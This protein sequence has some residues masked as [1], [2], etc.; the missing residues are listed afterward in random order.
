MRI[1]KIR[2]TNFRSFADAEIELTPYAALVGPNGG[3][4]STILCAL[5]VFF[6]ATDF[7]G[8]KN[9]ELV[10]EDFHRKN[11]K[12]PIEITVTFADLSAE[13]QREFAEYYRGGILV[14]TA[15]AIF[16]PTTRLAIVKQ[17]GQRKIMEPFREFFELFNGGRR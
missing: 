3:G 15:R 9:S 17:Y 5:N 11:T 7:V 1:S 8:S 16:D 6:R 13:A 2:I 4:K 10:E 12:E 14:V